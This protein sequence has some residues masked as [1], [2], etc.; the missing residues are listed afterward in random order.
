MERLKRILYRILFPGRAVVFLSL[1]VLIGSMVYVFGFGHASDWTAYL[2]YAVSAYS[3]TIICARVFKLFQGG[4][5][6]RLYQNRYVHRYLTDIPFKLRVSLY[7]SLGFNLFYAAVNLGSGL[8]YRSVWF[9]TL[10][11]YYILLSVMRFLL[12]RY[13]GQRGVGSR[14]ST[15]WNRYRVCGAILLPMNLALAGVIV[16]VL[17]ENE[18]FEYPGTLIYAMAL[19][20]F[21]ITITAAV[22]VVKYRKYDSP[23]LSGAKAVN[24]AAA[25][26]SMLALETAMLTRFD[27]GKNPENFS[28]MMVGFTGAIV[29]A[30]VGVMAVYMIVH[31]TQRLKRMGDNDSKTAI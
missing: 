1:T 27:S 24:L 25:L 4:V 5:R 26:V 29:C 20:T 17:H 8:Y 13:V 15:E 18:G 12:L 7:L 31:A 28:Q 23:V 3:L 6:V 30:I 2:L 9:G 21:C 14:H 11:V 19:Y 10:A 22:N 16:L